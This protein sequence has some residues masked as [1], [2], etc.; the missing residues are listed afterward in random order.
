MKICKKCQVEN[1]VN[2]YGI[3]SECCWGKG[4]KSKSDP[5]INILGSEVEAAKAIYAD[6]SHYIDQYPKLSKE[7]KLDIAH[8]LLKRS[9]YANK[10]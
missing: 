1:L 7:L 2:S 9:L 6:L 8:D 5:E 4:P 3:C 10:K